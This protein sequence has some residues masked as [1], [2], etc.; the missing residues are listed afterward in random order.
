MRG[1]KASRELSPLKDG[2]FDSMNWLFGTVIITIGVALFFILQSAAE[3]S[4]LDMREK[5]EV[6]IVLTD[7][8]FRPAQVRITPGTKVIFSTTRSGDF[9]PASN[10]HPA[11]SIYPEF[12][13]KLPIEPSDT[14]TF[15]PK[16]GV[17]GY[18]DHVR[19]YFTGILYVES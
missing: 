12:D 19:S 7:E 3:D 15:V 5:G 4:P 13:P 1:W 8:G 18:H 6:S 16:A 17:W 11:H 14:W 2:G 10:A 9:W